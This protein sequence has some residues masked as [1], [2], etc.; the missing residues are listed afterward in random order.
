MFDH[1]RTKR[2]WKRY[3][4]PQITQSLST[5]ENFTKMEKMD[6]SH[7]LPNWAIQVRKRE[8][9]EKEARAKTQKAAEE[10]VIMTEAEDLAK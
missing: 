8:A 2:H 5:S 1:K 4:A 6:F 9:E 10:E 3:D 7:Q